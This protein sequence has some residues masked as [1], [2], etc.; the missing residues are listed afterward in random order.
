MTFAGGCLR[1]SQVYECPVDVAA[2]PAACCKLQLES[3]IESLQRNPLTAGRKLH[4][5]CSLIE[6]NIIYGQD[7]S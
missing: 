7:I 1:V 3:S 4:V 6:D 2:Y 5:N